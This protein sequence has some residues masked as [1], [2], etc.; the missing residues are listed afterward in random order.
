[1]PRNPGKIFEQCVAKS[2]PKYALLH[3]LH[4]S[5]QSFCGNSDL[6]FS[7]KNPFDYLLWDS[8]RRYLYALELKTVKGKSIGFERTKEEQSEIHYHQIVGLNKV[9]KF[10]NTICGFIIEFRALEKTVFIDIHDFNKLIDTIQ[11]KSF[12]YDD[13]AKYGIPYFVIPQ[14]KKRVRYTYDIDSLLSQRN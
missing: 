13:L 14:K 8:Q 9:A 12:T 1:M 4:D 10:E 7:S 3:R 6:R 11:K 2:I 5:A